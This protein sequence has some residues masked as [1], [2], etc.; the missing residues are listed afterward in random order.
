MKMK[1]ETSDLLDRIFA[2]YNAD[3][4]WRIH[5]QRIRQE[6]RLYQGQGNL[7]SNADA[8]KRQV[9]AQENRH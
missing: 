4:G 7:P 8:A 1:I 5:G 9:E 2:E 6:V 3:T